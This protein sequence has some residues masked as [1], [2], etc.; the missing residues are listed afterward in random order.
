M[1]LWEIPAQKKTRELIPQAHCTYEGFGSKNMKIRVRILLNTMVG[2]GAESALG[3]SLKP[4]SGENF[5]IG[6][7]S[8]HLSTYREPDL[9]PSALQADWP[10][11]L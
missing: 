6:K 4:R 5:T 3:D 2:A 7:C 10:R 11:V 9:G 1:A 8:L